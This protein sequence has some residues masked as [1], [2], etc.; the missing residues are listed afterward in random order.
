MAKQ[1]T[2]QSVEKYMYF[3]TGGWIQSAVSDERIQIARQGDL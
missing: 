1:Y 2:W 3:R